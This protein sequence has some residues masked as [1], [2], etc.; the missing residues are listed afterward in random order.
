[1][2][3]YRLGEEIGRGALG[4]VVQVVETE[5]GRLHAGKLLHDSFRD[6]PR[7]V[8]RFG[9][10][11]RL[12]AELRH[13]NVV[14]VVDLLS[15]DEREV[16]LMELVPGPSLATLL[17][18][19]G[20]LPEKRLTTLAAGIARGLEAAHHLGLVHRDLK[21]ANVLLGASQVP[22]LVDFGLARTT[23]LAAVDPG[24]FALVGTPD[25]MAPEAVDPL[26][27]DARSD[28]Y[29]LGCLLFE[30]TAGR[31][32]YSGASAFA[33]LDAHR[34][35]P[36]PDL[37]P[38][39]ERSAAL[40]ELIRALLSKSPAD[41]PQSAAAVAEVL[42]DLAASR[43]LSPGRAHS[44]TPAEAETCFACQSPLVARVPICFG[45]VEPLLGLE[46]GAYTLFVVGPGKTADKLD[47][48]L[49]HA[50]VDWL[51]ARPNLGLDPTPLATKTPRLPFVLASGL[52][53]KAAKRLSSSLEEIGLVCTIE[54]GGALSFPEMRRKT[55]KLSGRAA[56]IMLGSL[57]GVFHMLLKLPLEAVVGVVMA[58]GAGV[59]GSG[60]RLATRPATR[61]LP[62]Q[63]PPT[64]RVGRAIEAAVQ[65]V[66]V[67]KARR[68]R[69]ALRGILARLFSV[70]EALGPKDD[71]DDELAAIIAAVVSATLRLDTLDEAL[72]Q[73]DLRQPSAED[74]T[75]LLERDRLAGRL[76]EMSGRL[77]AL[78]TRL[79]AA[80]AHSSGQGDS[81]AL[82]ELRFEVAALEEVVRP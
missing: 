35:A 56:A 1:M 75:R 53:A 59:F 60:W 48:T 69:E 41:R 64:P 47:V 10:E 29:A 63:A 28:L 70:Q 61:A 78:R 54:A 76:L 25:Y 15:I 77:E 20:P 73:S 68:H 32:P 34:R 8:E 14:R 2:P 39:P 66:G 23:S 71:L 51:A 50:L 21:P 57:C 19:E 82:A 58:G 6:D 12:L 40:L 3:T 30:M 52:S 31:P 18:R 44:P 67:L 17:A 72:C 80:R 42:E 46:V 16:L 55:W 7:A 43:A 11:A 24:A 9:R 33:L 22:K 79:L 26:A 65:A 37:E 74:R 4:K 45:C 27:V 49:R 81:R 38:T 13:E 36:I 62:A 5:S